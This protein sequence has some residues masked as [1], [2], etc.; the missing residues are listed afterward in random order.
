MSLMVIEPFLLPPAVGEK[1]T[2]M[3]Q[4]APTPRL[5]PQVLICAK[6]P[7][8]TILEMVNAAVPVLVTV[9]ACDAL[10]VPTG[11][12][13]KVRLVSDKLTTGAGRP[14]PARTIVCGL[15]GALSVMATEPYRLPGA[16]GVKVRLMV[17]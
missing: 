12:L 14:F 13:G 8:T 7:V 17:Q 2:L 10:V 3:T 1:V 6:L 9:T 16:V 4:F 15:S 5:D 11:W